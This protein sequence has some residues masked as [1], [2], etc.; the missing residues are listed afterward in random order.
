MKTISPMKK[1][2][3]FTLAF[4]MTFSLGFAFHSIFTNDKPMKK[5]PASGAFFL[6]AKTEENERMVPNP[7]RPEY[8]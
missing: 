5:L 6:N 7:P 1:T 2:F 4:A 8:Q 3:L